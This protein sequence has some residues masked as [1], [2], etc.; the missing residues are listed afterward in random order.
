M[1]GGRG[2]HNASVQI[3]PAALAEN[4]WCPCRLPLQVCV[5]SGMYRKLAMYEYSG[6]TLCE[7][8]DASLMTAPASCTIS[9][10]AAWSQI[11]S[12]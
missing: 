3:Q 8:P 4:K 5:S 9:A 11:F 2:R 6:S 12:R 10:P 7:A 1:H